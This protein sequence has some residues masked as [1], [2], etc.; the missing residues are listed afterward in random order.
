M[1][2]THAAYLTRFSMKKRA[3]MCGVA[4]RP[5]RCRVAL[6]VNSLALRVARPLAPDRL[7][8]E[9]VIQNFVGVQVRRVRREE[10]QLD[11][12]GM[13]RKPRAQRLGVVHAQV[14]QDGPP[15]E[16]FPPAVDEAGLPAEVNAADEDPGEPYFG[17]LP[18]DD[19]AA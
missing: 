16:L 12:C 5:S 11:F 4:A 9:V 19:W 17:K 8:L 7:A 18:A 3:T 10:E 15:E 14:A 13:L 1:D 6:S 2:D